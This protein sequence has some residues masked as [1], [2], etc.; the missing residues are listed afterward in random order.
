MLRELPESRLVP[1]QSI[2]D[3]SGKTVLK[4][5]I[6]LNKTF[7]AKNVS[8]EKTEIGLVVSNLA[9]AAASGVGLNALPNRQSLSLT[10][11]KRI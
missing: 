5:A 2:I 6:V 9:A 1:E 8:A 7:A 11:W 3:K 10:L 4:W